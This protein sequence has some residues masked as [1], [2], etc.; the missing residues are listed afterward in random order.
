MQR[1]STTSLY[2]NPW[3]L[4][5][6][7]G[8]EQRADRWE[9]LD[10]DMAADGAKAR[11]VEEIHARIFSDHLSIGDELGRGTFGIAYACLFPQLSSEIITVKLPLSYF[12]KPAV[13]LVENERL[14]KGHTS[15]DRRKQAIFEFNAEFRSFEQIYDPRALH[16][17]TN[18]T[19]GQLASDIDLHRHVKMLSELQRMKLHPGR[20]HIHRVIHYD[21]TIPA[22]FSEACNGTLQQLRQTNPKD[23]FTATPLL[24]STW[25]MSAEWLRVARHVGSAML[26]MQTMGVVHLDIK[27]SNIFYRKRSDGSNH[28]M[29]SDFGFCSGVRNTGDY[30]RCR[31]TLYFEPIA[32]R[33]PSM[34]AY[35]PPQLSLYTFA[36]LM[37]SCL[38]LPG[39]SFPH[40]AE[41]NDLV[42]YGSIDTE[43]AYFAQ[44]NRTI[45][46]LF[47]PFYDKIS[48][49]FQK[50]YPEWCH[51]LNIL[52]WDYENKRDRNTFSLLRHFMNILLLKKSDAEMSDA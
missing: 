32:W 51:I 1:C 22:I 15:I 11:Q 8:T 23:L 49:E 40:S 3:L 17:Q 14:K 6:A 52:R 48:D 4:P 47:P 37:V 41:K 45:A 30:L 38:K 13:L 25:K 19:Y 46:A 16:D 42:T 27:G 33:T 50:D 7:D 5:S 39:I 2:A 28:Y 21:A 12:L 18:F 35:N 36:A 9:D 10:W 34:L 43:I 26:Y 44:R 20:A 24:N 31:T 29:L